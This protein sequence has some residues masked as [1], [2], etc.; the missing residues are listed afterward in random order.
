MKNIFTDVM[1]IPFGALELLRSQDTCVRVSHTTQA[2][3][4][5]VT[6]IGSHHDARCTLCFVLSR[7]HESSATRSALDAH[8]RARAA[9]ARRRYTNIK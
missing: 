2:P 6:Y 4:Q 9:R 7:S 8:P 3:P 1:P 5:M